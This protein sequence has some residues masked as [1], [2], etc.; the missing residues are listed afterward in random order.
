M[1][2]PADADRV[3]RP[4]TC[5]ELAASAINLALAN[6]RILVCAT[7]VVLVPTFV[8]G[9]AALGYWREKSATGLNPTGGARTAELIGLAVFVFGGLLA[10]AAGVHAATNL[11]GP[12]GRLAPVGPCRFL[13][14]R[15]LSSWPASPSWCCRVSD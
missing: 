4:K 7:A 15:G 5:E 14:D 10:Q 1:V 11:A 8:V 2:G 12:H 13:P 9:G 6:Y 3:P